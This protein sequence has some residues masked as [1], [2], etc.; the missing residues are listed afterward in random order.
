MRIQ[1]RPVHILKEQVA[2]IREWEAQ[3]RRELGEWTEDTHGATLPAVEAVDQARAEAGLQPPRE[4]TTEDIS[5]R[6]YELAKESGGKLS[7][8]EAVDQA[9]AEAGLQPPRE[10]TT[11]D[12][13][14]RAHELAKESGGKLS[15]AA[16]VDQARAEAATLASRGTSARSQQVWERRQAQHGKVQ[17]TLM[18]TALALER[19]LI[20]HARELIAAARRALGDDP[21]RARELAIRAREAMSAISPL[22]GKKPDHGPARRILQGANGRPV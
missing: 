10:P 18:D 15:T 6:A 16:A 19:R 1:W 22:Y 4:P 20:A 13:S 17:E 14:A 2:N 7:T 5:A 3:S 21:L 11:Q 12:I 8:S 9:R